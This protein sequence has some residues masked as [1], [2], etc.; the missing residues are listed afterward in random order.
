MC[1]SRV[2][3][4]REQEGEWNMTRRVGTRGATDRTSE[5]LY[6]SAVKLPSAVADPN[7]VRPKVVPLVTHLARHSLAR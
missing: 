1:A 7:E 2:H 4:P 6:V 5:V 3:Q